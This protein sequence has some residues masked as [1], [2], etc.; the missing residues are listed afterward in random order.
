MLIGFGT[1]AQMLNPYSINR[2]S[3]NIKMYGDIPKNDTVAY[4]IEILNLD[5]NEILSKWFK[6]YAIRHYELKGRDEGLNYIISYAPIIDS[7]LWNNYIP[8]SK[9]STDNI[10]RYKQ[11][12]N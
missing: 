1:K 8:F 4:A 12:K 2:D 7:W 5:R 9:S 11:L 10:L 3:I 6:V